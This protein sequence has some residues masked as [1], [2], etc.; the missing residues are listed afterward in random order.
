MQ[1]EGVGYKGYMAYYRVAP[2]RARLKRELDK[3]AARRNL[4]S[5]LSWSSS[6]AAA[7]LL[8]TTL[9]C[10]YSPYSS[11]AAVES[12]SKLQQQ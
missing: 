1:W 3:M 11:T 4:C 6:V 9:P 10:Y 8:Y 7:L 12:E 2:T 5:V